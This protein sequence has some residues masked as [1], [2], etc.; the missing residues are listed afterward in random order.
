MA[1]LSGICDRSAAERLA[2]LKLYV[3]RER[4]PEPAEADEYYPA[5]LIG[6]AV[7]NRAGER[8]GTVAAIYNFGAGDL[9]EVRPDAGGNTE[10]LPFD[11][12]SVPA[13]ALGVE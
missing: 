7:V 8:L 12:T 9:I 1:R 5:D 6:L 13:V 10:L 3:P 11:E 2:N 4:L